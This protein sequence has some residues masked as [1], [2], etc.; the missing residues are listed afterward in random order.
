M[1]FGWK[2]ANQLPIRAFITKGLEFSH[3]LF[4]GSQMFLDG[5]G[6][7]SFI[8]FIHE[9]KSINYISNIIKK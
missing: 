4:D 3:F 2:S 6:V 1:G 9:R 7:K 8:L 5:I